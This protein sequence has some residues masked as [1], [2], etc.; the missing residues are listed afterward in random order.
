[1]ALFVKQDFSPPLLSKKWIAMKTRPNM[2]IY[3]RQHII[4]ILESGLLFRED[5]IEV[6]QEAPGEETSWKK[7][8]GTKAGWLTSGEKTVALIATT[9]LILVAPPK[10][11]HRWTLFRMVSYLFIPPVV[12]TI[13][14]TRC[15]GTIDMLLDCMRDY[16][17]L[18]RRATACCREYAALHAKL[19]SVVSAVESTQA[20]LSRQQSELLLLMSRATST[21]LGNVPWLQ[22]DVVC[23]WESDNLMKI[24]HAFLVVQSSLLKYIALAHIPNS[25]AKNIYK[26]HNE[27]IYWLHNVL[28]VHLIQEFK[29]N[30]ESLE[31]MY[32]LLKNY[33][34]KDGEISQKK[35]GHAINTTW[36]YSDVH[37]G[38]ARSCLE[39]RI[40]LD[41]C[42]NLDLFLDSCAI[43]KQDLDLNVLD[44]DID[45]II[46]DVT[47]CLS[48]IQSSQIRLKKMKNK[49]TINEETNKVEEE[50]IET[51]I[52]KIEDKEP[53]IKDE[54]FYFIK[55]DDDLVTLPAGDITT[56]PGK[57]EKEATKI[58][59]K[60]LQRKL[61]K[62]ED[63]MR[64]RER[65]ALYKTMPHL[66]NF[67]EFPRQMK[68]E[69][70]V[71]RKGYLSKIRKEEHPKNLK[72]KI[73]HKQKRNMKFKLKVS[74]YEQESDIIDVYEANSRL[75]FKSK[76]LTFRKGKKEMEIIK[77]R[78]STK[79]NKNNIVKS[80]LS[81]LSD[82][83]V[84]VN[85]AE[86]KNVHESRNYRFTKKDLELST[87]SDSDYEYNRI[88]IL[89][90]VR[91]H[92]AARKKNYPAKRASIDKE[93]ESLKPIEYSFGTGMAMAS[94]LQVNSLAKIPNLC[95]EEVFIGDGEVSNDSGN[96]EDA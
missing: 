90:D 40:A 89:K 16:M 9:A 62:R 79:Q 21:L 83:P 24:H 68:Y 45:D 88:Q 78:K 38:V 84:E 75:N 82:I 11:L 29:E 46:D 50:N 91:R 70:F 93:D 56:G 7:A 36:L 13:H 47:K 94:V 76:L 28:I 15:R 18:A 67:P 42:N 14:R 96:D 53:E 3:S 10:N 19:A 48:T 71:E 60:E 26:N 20:L 57:K 74:L 69:D 66:Q 35:P 81:E 8:G 54:V 59:L 34:T 31:R 1:M 37:T 65:Q 80:D 30:Y 23:E 2:L 85:H 44:K 27:R 33:G 63:M 73:R 58:V 64:E 87:S 61:V 92:R 77:W 43:N 55:T 17:T 39:L 86:N 49:Y 5:S 51:N 25:K 12:T 22:G 6:E 41:K 4:A 52:L 72:P 32:R 95:Q